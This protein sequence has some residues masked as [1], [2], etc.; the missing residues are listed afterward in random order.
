MNIC[1]FC[2]IIQR[3]VEMNIQ[4]DKTVHELNVSMRKNLHVTGVTE[5]VSFDENTV[6]LKTSCGELNIEGGDIKISVLDTE[7]GIVTLEG[8]IDSMYYAEEK[9]GDKRGFFGKVFG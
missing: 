6:T 7:R 5:V 3:S 9:S 4:K 8:R 2:D 1:A